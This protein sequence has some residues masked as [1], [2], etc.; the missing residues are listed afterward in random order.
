MGRLAQT[1]AIRVAEPLVP[2]H[3]RSKAMPTDATPRFDCKYQMQKRQTTP[4]IEVE[5]SDD[6]G[7]MFWLALRA[8]VLRRAISQRGTA[9]ERGAVFNAGA[10]SDQRTPISSRPCHWLGSD[11]APR[12]LNETCNR[13]GLLLRYAPEPMTITASATEH[14]FTTRHC[15]SNLQ[16]FKICSRSSSCRPSTDG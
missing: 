10:A 11:V 16:C 4:G 7:S 6:Q 8:G 13:R 14:F 12:V 5:E 1:L 2:E 15:T 9:Q 3:R